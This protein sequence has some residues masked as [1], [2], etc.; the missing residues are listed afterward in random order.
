MGGLPGGADRSC[1]GSC[2]SR[3]VPGQSQAMGTCDVTWLVLITEDDEYKMMLAQTG[4]VLTN[5]AIPHSS[6]HHLSGSASDGMYHIRHG[7]DPFVR[8]IVNF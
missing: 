5:E 3:S 4:G 2:A 8:R 1:L 6:G 7:G